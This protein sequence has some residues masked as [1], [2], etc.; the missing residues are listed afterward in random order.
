MKRNKWIRISVIC[1]FLLGL[2]YGCCYNGNVKGTCITYTS[3]KGIPI[4]YKC[5]KKLV[6]TQCDKK[7]D[8]CGY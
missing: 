3:D 8:M 4:T 1:G 6:D 7:T 5:P 2:N